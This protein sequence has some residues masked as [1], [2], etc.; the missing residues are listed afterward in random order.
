MTMN[1]THSGIFSQ[2]KCEKIC[3]L[4]G[5]PLVESARLK[6]FSSTWYELAFTSEEVLILKLAFPEINYLLRRIS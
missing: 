3:T 4:L 1:Q 5:R 2:N 6:L